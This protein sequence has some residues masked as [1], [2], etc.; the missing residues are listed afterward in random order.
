M[1]SVICILQYHRKALSKGAICILSRLV[2][3]GVLSIIGAATQ[4]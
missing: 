1:D 2:L 4:P 3:W